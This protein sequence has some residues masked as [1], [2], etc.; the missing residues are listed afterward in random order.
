MNRGRG[1]EGGNGCLLTLL[2]GL[3]QLLQSAE[4]MEVKMSRQRTAHFGEDVVLQCDIIEH[5]PSELD[6]KKMAVVWHQE[7]SGVNGKKELYLFLGGKHTSNRNG[8]RLD[9]SELEKGNAALFL[10]Q[11]QA[12]DEGAY[13]CSVTV[14]PD[15][16][17]GTTILEV[18]AE[19][20]VSL[21]P[22]KVTVE[23]GTEKTLSCTVD[24]FYPSSI[25]IYWQKISKHTQDQSVSAKDICN[26]LP[27][28]NGDS[29]F[30]VSSKL[31]LQPS[32]QDDGNNY[33]CIVEHR[34]FPVKAVFSAILTVTDP[35]VDW[36]VQ[37]LPIVLVFVVLVIIILC[38]IAYYAYLSKRQPTIMAM[39]GNTDLKHLEQARLQCLFSG[40]RP[41]H[42]DLAFF[43][44]IHPQ[45]KKQKIFS[46]NTS[47]LGNVEQGNENVPLL[48]QQDMFSFYP[49]LLAKP[50]R[51]FDASCQIYI[52]PDVRTVE[53]FELLLEV[54]HGALQHTETKAFRVTA[55]PLLD[56]I[57]CATDMPK[58]DEPLRLSCRIHSYFPQTINV[59]W[60]KNDLPLQTKPFVSSSAEGPDGFFSCSSSI[61]YCPEASDIGTRFFCKANLTDSQQCRES[62]WELKT[63]VFVPQ[64]SQIQCE[65][66][67]PE[68]GKPITLSCTVENF[69]P[70]EC[71]ICWKRDFEELSCA[72]SRTEEQWHD[73]ESNLYC[74]KSQIFFTP[75]AEDHAVNFTAEITHCNT[76]KRKSYPLMLKGFPKVTD[77]FLEPTDA[78]YGN[79]LSVRCDVT[80]F[81]PGDI[82]IDWFHDNHLVRNDIITE[83]PM[84]DSN[85]CYKLSSTFQLTP[86]AFDFNKAISCRVSHEK[87]RKPIVKEVY[88]KL[89]AKSPIVS[90]IKLKQNSKSISL[91]ISISHFAPQDIRVIWYKDWEK[92]S[93][94]HNPKDIRIIENLCYFVSKIELNQ[95]EEVFKKTIRCEISHPSTQS[96]KEKS[97]V[98]G[99]R[100]PGPT[101]EKNNN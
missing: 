45:N 80:D 99:N 46:W 44:I 48:Q 32:S 4:T 28:E 53:N 21:T 73:D 66:T 12:K 85:G 96:F 33:S 24:K 79:K 26:E 100:D 67:M 50:R 27:V 87:L 54:K 59:Q 74:K 81:C 19:P 13:T 93:E 90:E 58:S 16:A 92:I 88:L 97:I 55:P 49:T 91:E 56:Q 2:V 5:S 41:K 86:T 15:H 65:P 98:L 76:R 82:N 18:L 83:D 14:T 68:C 6:I 39:V 64:V 70:D 8:S 84:E 78:E 29:T 77:I 17:E 22:S 101:S 69:F 37:A 11:I 63:L 38:G 71:D 57:Q 95:T 94:E 47:A 31:R 7:T 60:Y 30:S 1:L 62:V 10:P 9:E 36:K 52:L 40:F 3:G 61:T 89:P 20:V 42:L 43:L 35:P 25:V 23:R 72:I 34:S 51:T 75:S